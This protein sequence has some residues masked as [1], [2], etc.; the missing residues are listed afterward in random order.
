MQG[1]T[2]S[3]ISKAQALQTTVKTDWTRMIAPE[4]QSQLAIVETLVISLLAVA[5][6]W[7]VSPD[8]P[9]MISASFHWVWFAPVLVALRYGVLMGVLSILVL[10]ANAV[11]LVFIAHQ[12]AEMPLAYFLGGGL[13]TLVVGEFATVWTERNQRKEEANLYL[14]ERL[15]RL[16]RRF[17]LMKLS[18]DRLEQ[19]MLSRPGSLRSAIHDLRQ[20]EYLEGQAQATLPAAQALMGILSQ[21]CLVEEAALY[22][23]QQLSD[24]RIK[25]GLPSAM[26]GTPPLLSAQDSLLNYAIQHKVLAHVGQLTNDGYQ[27]QLI[28]APLYETS[29]GLVG[30][31]AVRSMPFFALN[32]ENLQLM[33]VILSYYTDTATNADLTNRVLSALPKPAEGSFAEEIARLIRVAE[34]TKVSSELLVL[35]FSG[36]KKEV[37]PEQITTL[38]R[39]LDLMWQTQIAGEP[40]LFVLMPFGTQAGIQGFN[41]RLEGWLKSRHGM[42]FDRLKVD[43]YTISLSSERDLERLSRI[44]QGQL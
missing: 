34:R 8:D 3:G 33:M 23:A 40:A 20:Q 37:I 35:R 27:S 5:M 6:G 15:T 9:L 36:E 26:L 42:S 31:L 18:H 28:I 32:D 30:V 21:Y 2:R 14:E 38:K 17:L 12:A 7:L 13:L 19:E 43:R 25:L 29:F 4:S 39:G 22:P 41:H 44:T 11:F 1:A 24:D 16:T 10:A